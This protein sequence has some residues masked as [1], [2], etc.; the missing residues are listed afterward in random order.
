MCIKKHDSVS[1]ILHAYIPRRSPIPFFL[2][3]K[4]SGSEKLMVDRHDVQYRYLI[5]VSVLKPAQSNTAEWPAWYG[6]ILDLA[7]RMSNLRK[8]FAEAKGSNVCHISA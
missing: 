1:E 8:R 3:S 2:S 4:S 5:I 6:A 7:M